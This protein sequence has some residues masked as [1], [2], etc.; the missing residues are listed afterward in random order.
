MVKTAE[1]IAV[2]SKC[3]G[4][5]C[6]NSFGTPEIGRGVQATNGG[7]SHNRTTTRDDEGNTCGVVPEDGLFEIYEDNYG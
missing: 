4:M 3:K 5:R 7:N 6:E 1:Q 2:S